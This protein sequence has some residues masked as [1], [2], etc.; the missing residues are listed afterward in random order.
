MIPALLPFETYLRSLPP[1]GLGVPKW[2]GRHRWGQLYEV[3][4]WDAKC[5]VERP[6]IIDTH[7]KTNYHFRIIPTWLLQLLFPSVEWA[8]Y[9]TYGCMSQHS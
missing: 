9:R 4:L 7:A 1:P 8:Y 6:Y 5:T 3:S 2:L